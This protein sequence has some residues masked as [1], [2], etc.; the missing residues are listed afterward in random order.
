MHRGE[1]DASTHLMALV[2]LILAFSFGR[3]GDDISEIFHDRI[4]LSNPMDFRYLIVLEVTSILYPVLSHP[5][6]F[7]LSAAVGGIDDSA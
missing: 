1:H 4:T 5:F 6:S 2:L 7:R 3:I